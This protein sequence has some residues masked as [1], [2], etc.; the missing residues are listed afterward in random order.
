MEAVMAFQKA[1]GLKPDGIVG[2][3]TWAKLPVSNSGLLLS[4]RF[5]NKIIVHCT[6]SREGKNLTVE[7]IRRDHKARGWADIGYHYVVYLDG[8]IHNGRDGNLIGSH[9][10]GYNANS[11]GVVYVG[12]LNKQGKATDTRTDAQKKALVKL[13]KE[14][15]RL[16]PKA[17]IYGHRDFAAKDCP[18]F[19]AKEEYKNI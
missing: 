15:R 10:Y 1:N 17:K 18:C 6:A 9:C 3:K 14:L 19:D 2:E 13:L 8:S 12:G 5:I 7:D 16:Y 11:I 4:K